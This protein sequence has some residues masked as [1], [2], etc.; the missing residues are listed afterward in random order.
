MNETIELLPK[1]TPDYIIDE[2]QYYFDKINKGKSDCFTLDNAILLVNMAMV[3][4]RLNDELA[5]EIKKAIRKIK[6]KEK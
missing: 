3:N 1:Y 2:V 6:E 5:D 4:N